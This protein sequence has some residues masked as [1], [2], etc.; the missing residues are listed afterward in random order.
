MS[1][2]YT[3]LPPKHECMLLVWMQVLGWAKFLSGCPERTTLFHS[4]VHASIFFGKDLLAEARCL[5]L[6]SLQLESNNLKTV[7]VA[8]VAT[9]QL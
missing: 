4:L 3:Q 8:W 9:D 1:E 7:V 2:L 5:H 6:F